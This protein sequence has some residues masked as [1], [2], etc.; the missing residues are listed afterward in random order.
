VWDGRLDNRHDLLLRLGPVAGG[1]PTDAAIAAAAFERWGLD[2][3]RSLVGEWSV[4]IWDPH[5]RTLHL[6]RDYMGVRPLYFSRI[7]ATVRWSTSLAEIATRSNCAGALD[8][9]FVAR[10]MALR[11]SG[12]TTPYVGIRG[13]TAASCVSVGASGECRRAFWRLEPGSIRYRDERDYEVHL[14][15]LWTDAVACRLRTRDCVWAELSGGFDSSSV[16]CM[17]AALIASGRVPAAGVQPISYVT[18]RSAEGDERRFIEA[19]ETR[20]GRRTEILGVE[21]HATHRDATCDWLTPFAP[22]G[23][24]LAGADRV[25]ERGGR[26]VLTGRTGDGVMGCEPDNSIA[27]YDDLAAGAVGSAIAKLRLWSRQSGKPFIELA[28]ALRRATRTGCARELVRRHA[29]RSR[30]GVDL[31]T[32]NLRTLVPDDA[33]MLAEAAAGVRAAKRDLAVQLLGYSWGCQL[34]VPEPPH[35]LQFTHP[36]THR[37][38]V[39]FIFAIPGEQLSAPGEIRS[40]MR[41]AFA[42]LVPERVLRR[43]SKGYYPPSSTRALRVAALALR[44][45]ERLAVVQRGWIDP[46]RLDTALRTL[47]EGGGTSGKEVQR[48]LRLEEWIHAHSRRA[49]AAIPQREEVRTNEVLNA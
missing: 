22:Y 39:D 14:R 18:L 49:P 7:G 36:Y 35:G 46:G 8:G 11:F 48:V 37:P 25:R 47:I 30:A 27:V 41:R 42:G 38:L 43:V 4:A 12:E 23:V 15:S 40:L 6:A 29:E 21:D 2:G 20:I 1:A 5:R 17:A 16:V 33:A 34:N 44:P 31:L 26:I 28:W 9:E 13:V 10:F 32:A 19:V 3:L 24:A 45:V